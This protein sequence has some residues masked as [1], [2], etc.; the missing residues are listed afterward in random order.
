MG[1][2]WPAHKVTPG[3]IEHAPAPAE[4][5][6]GPGEFYRPA[7]AHPCPRCKL[8]DRPRRRVAF[9]ARRELCGPCEAQARELMVKII[10]GVV[11]MFSLAG[12]LR[13]LERAAELERIIGRGQAL[14]QVLELEGRGRDER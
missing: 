1:D 3:R 10:G 5:E 12:Y 9:W 11:G 4:L 14:A 6:P 8:R 7:P 2:Y 13:E